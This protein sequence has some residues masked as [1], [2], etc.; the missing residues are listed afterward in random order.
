MKANFWK[1]LKVAG[2]FLFNYGDLTKFQKNWMRSIVPFFTWNQKNFL[3]TMEMMEKNP[4]YFS[5]MYRTLYEWFPRITEAIEA[6]E[7]G[8]ELSAHIQA[9][10]RQKDF[11][12]L[13]KYNMYK[14]RIPIDMT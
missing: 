9:D 1:R 7:K 13:P 8:T 5:T 12:Y 6:D 14:V 4:V 2:K 11:R 10:E 3:L